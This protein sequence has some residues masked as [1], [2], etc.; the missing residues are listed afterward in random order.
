MRNILLIDRGD[1]SVH[2]FK[3]SLTN[4]GYRLT[5]TQSLAAALQQI[6]KTGID[7]IIIDNAL[8]PEISRS[9]TFSQLSDTIPKLVLTDNITIKNNSLWLDDKSAYPVDK[10]MSLRE[11]N[12]W[13][14]KVIKN[15]SIEQDNRLLLSE[16][17]TKEKALGFFDE[18]T[19]VFNSTSDLDRS[20]DSIMGRA[21]EMTEAR[22]WVILLND[23]ALFEI[24]PIQAS[25]KIEQFKFDRRSSFAGWVMKKGIP[26]I[27]QDVSK[28][29]RY[30]KKVDKHTRQK[31][32][33][34]LCAPLI[35]NKKVIGVTEL[36]NK[37]PG[38]AFTEVDLQILGNASHYVAMTIKRALL[39]YKIEEISITDDLT[40]IYNM[41]YLDQAVDIEIEKSRRYSSIFSLIFMDIDYF[42]KVNDNYGHL[43]G[44]RVLIELAQLL[45][46]SL[47]KVDVVSRYG[48]DEFVIILPQTP[49]DAC[50]MVA[51]RLRKAIERHVFIKDDGLSIK[52]TASFGIASYPDDAENKK[53]LLKLADSAMYRGK[54]STKNV[55]FAAS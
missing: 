46:E 2:K 55:V 49:R 47:R 18:I 51:E 35:I 14:S 37:K 5:N 32:I 41:R 30:N 20:L 22:D 6:K 38:S 4:K 28:D 10:R 52:I 13:I 44:S 12:S 42:K 1:S 23:A 7:L 39:Y 21:A 54:F 25:T 53:D 29:R 31:L 11:F 19:K 40:N 27:V 48:G 43:V 3:K 33:S 9:R 16:L 15:L 17:D 24:K 26:L 36:I 8:A 50:F 34:L 45:Q